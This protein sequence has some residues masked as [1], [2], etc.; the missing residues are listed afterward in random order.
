MRNLRYVPLL[1]GGFSIKECYDWMRLP[2]HYL[3]ESVN[4]YET[5]RGRLK[6]SI[7]QKL[8][9]DPIAWDYAIICLHDVRIEPKVDEENRHFIAVNESGLEARVI[10][11]SDTSG[12]SVVLWPERPHTKQ[13]YNDA[14]ITQNLEYG[15]TVHQIV[16]WHD[17][18]YNTSF[19]YE[20]TK[21]KPTHR[22]KLKDIIEEVCPNP[23]LVWVPGHIQ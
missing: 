20:V 9:L 2:T 18:N 3:A 8:F 16:L 15:D 23:S 10:N 4:D 19:V 12:V 22:R 13:G 17:L 5:K 21:N 6:H 7:V 11:V 14:Q 1:T